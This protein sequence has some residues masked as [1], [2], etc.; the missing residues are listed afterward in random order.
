MGAFDGGLCRATARLSVRWSATAFAVSAAFAVVVALL[1]RADTSARF[2]ADYTLSDGVLAWVLPLL[3]YSGV[4]R[5]SGSGRADDAVREVAR[6][7]ENRRT[8]FVGLVVATGLRVASISALVAPL[9]V[10]VARG[11]LDLPSLS[12]ALT[13]G[14]IA[15]L[16]GGAYVALFSLGSLFG[17]SGQG[18][19]V[20][21]GADFMLGALPSGIATAFPRAHLASL[22]G[23]PAVMG[24]AGWQS[25]GCL[26]AIGLGCLALGALRVSP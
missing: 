12:D 4:G 2:A 7:G 26:Y 17:R 1:E 19:A 20:L 6:H 16:G 14:W 3:A 24:L 13:S 25:T 22:I 23:G 15:A 18:R 8:A 10:V 9:S 21:L 11:R 5:V